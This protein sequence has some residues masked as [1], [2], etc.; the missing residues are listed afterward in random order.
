VSFAVVELVQMVLD[1]DLPHG[2]RLLAIVIANGINSKNPKAGYW[3]SIPKL[4]AQCGYGCRSVF[5]NLDTLRDQGLLN[6]EGRVGR[7]S[8][9]RFDFS[10]LSERTRAKTAHPTRAKTA[11]VA[12]DTHAKNVGTRA[13]VAPPRA[14]SAP[15]PMQKL[16]PEPEVEPVVEPV[17]NRK[18]VLQ[19]N[20]QGQQQNHLT[21]E[22]QIAWCKAQ[23]TPP[24]H[25]AHVRACQAHR[26][27]SFR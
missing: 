18:G 5:N 22:E 4:A 6:I 9:Y 26:A 16:H 7:S 14:N 17:I 25:D 20:S 1:S 23:I 15:P 10:A 19:K 3:A 21:R 12:A 24:L 13:T 2:P 11:Q 27:G 8:I